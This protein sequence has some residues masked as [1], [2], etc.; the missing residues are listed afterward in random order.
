[1]FGVKGSASAARSLKPAR[2]GLTLLALVAML[3]LATALPTL[4][5]ESKDGF[6]VAPEERVEEV[7]ARPPIA[8]LAL[9]NGNVIEFFD[10]VD[11]KGV[12]QGVVV[13]E[14][15]EPGNAGIQSD[16][17]LRNADA[18]EVFNAFADAQVE[19]PRLLMELYGDADLG[20]RGWARDM[21]V[22]QP[23]TQGPPDY[24]TC[25][26]QSVTTWNDGVDAHQALYNGAFTSTW[27]GPDSIPAHW[28]WTGNLG[29]GDAAGYKLVGQAVGVSAFYASVLYCWEDVD[30]AFEVDGQYAGNYISFSWRYNSSQPWN[31]FYSDQLDAVGKIVSY[32]YE[33]ANTYSPTATRL[34]FKMEI[35][36]AKPAD[37]FH[38]GA[39]WQINGPG[40][41]T[42][43]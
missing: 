22:G 4:A 5:R 6:I 36:N 14:A 21:L 11:E 17:R 8:S 25:P 1:M 38:I 12:S 41:Y 20:G 23:G 2:R 26:A 18:L 3:L 9:P 35:A 31:K 30:E 39:A 24:V 37:L 16:A 32:S 10:V 7:A 27:D 29:F 15:V 40:S 43:N 28:H 33:A 13:V 42:G 19:M 34:N